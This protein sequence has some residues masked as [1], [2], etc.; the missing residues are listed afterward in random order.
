MIPLSYAQRRLW[1]IDRF[2]GPSATYNL[3]FLI[4]LT[5][6]LD[7]AALTAAVRDVVVRHESLRTLIIDNADGVPAQ[8]VV[9]AEDLHLD[10]PL[11]EVAPADREAAVARAAQYAFTLAEEIPVRATLFRSGPQDHQLLLLAHHIATDGESMDPLVRD[12]AA[13]YT[14]R[15]G[16]A[17]PD[18]PELP[19]QYVDYTMWQRDLLGDENDPESILATQLDYW[20]GELTGVPQP[21]RLPADRPRPPVAGRHGDVVDFRIDAELYGRAE[22]L[23]QRTGV[24]APM[25]FQAALAALLQQLGAGADVTIGSTVAGRMDSQLDDLVGFFVNTWVL[26]TDLSGTPSFEDLLGRVR[27]KAMAAYDHQDAPFERLVEMLNPERSTAYHPLFQTMFTWETHRSVTLGLRGGLTAR[28]TALPTPTAKFDLEFSCFADP[29][30]PGLSVSLEY[31]TE[32]FDRSTAEAVAARYVRLVR[33]LVDAPERPV[34]LADV[35]EAGERALVLGTFNETAAETPELGIAGLVERRAA[36]TPDALAVVHDDTELTYA[37]LD[38]RAGLLARELVA[39][40]AG[41]ERVVGL[42]LPRSADLVVAML[43]ILKSGAAYLPID[44][45]Y[46]STRLDHILRDAR[47][48]LVLTSADTVGVLPTT[49]VPTLFVDDVDFD[50]DGSGAA[51]VELPRVRPANAAY[52]MYTSGST[53]VPKGVTITHR[54]VVNGVLRLADAIG[55]DAGT[56]TLA[57]TSVNFDVSVFETIT[58]LAVGGT[59]EVVRD[60]LVVGE[61]GGWSGG[62]I[63]TVPS[64]FAELLDQVGG[65]LQADAVVFAGEALPASLVERVREAIPGVRVVNAYG[66]TESFYATTFTA[67]DTW[68]GTGSA[69]IGAPLGNMRAY[70]L[71]AGLEPVAPGV[72][73]ELYVA[74]NV[75]RGYHSRAALTAERFL[76]DPFGEP[77]A[78]MYRTGDLARWTPDGQ[79]EYAGRDDAQVKVRGFRIEPG[80]IEAALTAHPGVAQAVVTT[81]AGRGST[82][83]VGY[84]VPVD[85]GEGG[86]DSVSSLGDLDLDLTAIVSARDL[87]RFVSGRLPEFMVPSVFVMLDRLPLAPNGKLDHKALPEPEFTGGEYRAPRTAEEVT[88]AAVYAEVLGLERVGVDDDFFAIGGDSIRSIQV[89]SRARAQGVDVT[90]R[91]IFECRTVAELAQAA[92]EGPGRPVLDELDGGGVGFVPLLPIG[93]YLTQ[94]GGGTDRFTMSMTVDLPAGIDERGLLATLG[95]VLDRHD[96][97]RSRLVSDPAPGL[98]VTGPGTVDAGTL[99]HRVTWSGDWDGAWR[100]QAAAELDAAADRLDAQRGVMA[101]FVWFDAGAGGAGRLLILLHHFVVDGVSWRILLPDLAEAWSQVRDGRTP[102]LPEV[103]TSVRRW[104][105]ALAEE[106]GSERRTGELALWRSIVTGPDPD[107]G[108]R[109]FDPAVDVCATVRTVHMDLPTAATET[110]LTTLPGAFR[111][112]VNDGLLAALALAVAKWRSGRGVAEDASA[113]TLIRLEG[114]GR[115]ETAAPGADLSRT[116]GWFTSVYPV[117]LDVAGVDV[118]DALAGGRAAGA[119][120]KAVKEQLLA[121]PDKGVGY[122]MLRHLNPET[123]EILERYPTGQI[124]FN[125]LGHY[126]GSGNMP[127]HLRGLGFTQADGTTELIADLDADMPALATLAVSAY[128][129]DTPQGPRLDARLDFPSGLLSQ[130]E[131]EELAALWRTALEGVAHHAGRPDA[132]GL[133]PSDVPLVTTDQAQ[134]E[135]WEERYPHLADVWPL[136]AMQDGLL[137]HAELAG[138]SFDAYQMQLVFHLNGEVDGARMRAAG[139]ALLER[140]P[141]LRAAFVM[142]D[143]GRRVQLVHEHVELPWAEYDLSD[144]A[145]GERAQRLKRHL[146]EEHARHFD[147]ATAPLVRMSLVK[148]AADRW[149][150]VFTA[151]HVLFDGWSL[152]LVMEDLLR[153]YGSAGDASGLGRIRDY[154]DF[155]TWLADRDEGAAARAWATELSGVESPTLLAPGAADSD[156]EPAGIAMADVPLAPETGRD[157]ARRAADLGITLNTLIQG[158][159]AV[160]LAGL[161]GRQDVVFGTTVSG[162]P[163]QVTGADEMVGLFINSLPVRVNCAPGTTLRELLT[164]LQERQSALLDHHHHGLLDIHQAVGLPT[165]FDTMV[166]YESFPIDAVALS[167]AGAAAGI[168]LTGISPLSGAHYPLVVMALAEPHLKVGI[169]YRPHVFDAAQVGAIAGR[170]ARILELLARDADTPVAALGILEDDERKRILTDWNDTPAATA[171]RTVPQV[172]EAHA[173]RTP[174]A[175]AVVDGDRTLTY[176]DLDERANRLA[177]VLAARGVGQESVVGLALPRSVE[178]IV[179]LLAVEKAGGAYLP[180]DPEYPADRLAFMLSDADPTLVVTD[181]RIAAGLPESPCPFLVLDEPDTAAEITA[182]SSEPLASAQAGHL[183]Q[184]AYLMYTSGS[185][186]RPKGVGVTHRGVVSLAAD[187]CYAGGNHERVLMHNAQ[188]FDASTYDQWIPLLGGGTIVI[189]PPGRLDAAT[190]AAAAREHDVTGVVMTAGLFMVIADEMPEAFTGVREVWS[191]GDAVAPALVRRVL[192]TCPGLRVVNGYGPT[193]ATMATS[194]HNMER[195][196]DIGEVVPIGRPLDS[197]QVYV[198]DAALRPVLPGVPGELYIGGERLARGYRNRSALTAERFVACPFGAPGE[199]MYRTGDVVAW[200]DEGLLVFHGRVDTQVKIRGFR[201]EPAEVEA[202]LSTHPGVAQAVVTVQED[203]AGERRLMGYVVPH[204][205]GTGQAAA[206]ERQVEEWETVYDQVYSAANTVWGEDFTGWDSTYTDRPLALH[207]MREWRDAAVRQI[208]ARAPRRVLEIGVGSGL[209]MAHVLPHVEQYWATD[210]SSAVI[211]RLAHEAEQAGYADRA[212]LRHRAADDVTGLPQGH[213]DT[214]VLNSVVQYFPDADYLDRVLAQAFELLAPGGRIIVGDVRNAATLRLFRAGVQHAHQPEAA[215]SQ[216]RAAITRAMLMEQE[217]VVDPEWFTQWAARHGAA[218]V[219]IRLK[220]GR[221]HNELTRHRYEAVLHKQPA[222]PVELTE[223]PPLY[224]GRQVGDLR[225]LAQLCA[226]REDTE[227][228]RVVGIPNARLTEEVDLAVAA[229]L[230]TAPAVTGPAV[231]PQD[232]WD[233]AAEQGWTVL[234][235]WSGAVAESF[236]VLVFPQGPELPDQLTGLFVPAGRPGR[237][238][239][240]EPA[241]AGRIGTLVGSLRDY[242]TERLP[243]HQVP[244]SVVAIAEV[245]LMASGKLDRKALPVADFVAQATGRDPR[246]PQEELL[247][248]LFA[249]VLGLDRVGIDDDFFALGGHSLLATRL[250]SRIRA[251]LGVEL[252]IRAVFAAPTVVG[253]SGHL[254]EGDRARPPMVRVEPRPERVPLSFAQRRLWFLDK[255]EGPSATYNAP[256]PLRLTGELDPDALAAAVR[257]VVTRH[258]SLRTLFAEDPDGTPYQRVLSA[259]EVRLDVPVVDV[260]ATE[261]TASIM[262]FASYRFDLATEIPVRTVLLRLAERDHVL[263]LMVH[264][265][266]SDGSSMAPMFRDLA[267]AYAARLAGQAPR[268]PELPAQYV[269]YTLWQRDLLGD[270]NDPDSL[271]TAQF[272]YWRGELTG[273]PQPLQLPTDRT[274]PP[275]AS[276]RGAH[277]DFA[278]DP[279]TVAGIGELARE[280]GATVAI[281]LEAALAV[282]L[283][284]LGGGD[285]VTIGSPIANRTDEN[286]TDMVGFFVNTWVLRA[287]LDGNPTFNDVLDQVRTKSLA[288]YDHQDVPFERLVEVLN[289]ERSTAY[290]P[291]FQVMFAWQNFN[292]QDFELSGLQVEFERVPNDTVKF[293]LFFNMADLPGRGVLGVLEYA[294]DLFDEDTARTIADRFV[295]LL[296]R[297]AAEPARPVATVDLVEPHERDLV[298]RG[299]NDTAAET[300]DLTV[301][302]LIAEQAART[303]EATAVVFGEEQL[304]YAELEARTDR[305][306]HALAARG[307]GP[308][309]IVGL[310]LPRSADLVVAMLG[311]L[312]AGGAYLPI[313]PKYPSTRLDH[314]LDDARPALILKSLSDLGE[315]GDLTDGGTDAPVPA[316]RPANAAYVMYTSGSTGVPKGVTITHRDVVN[317]VLRLAESIGIDADT[318]TLAGTSINFDV[319]VFETVTTLAKGGTVEVVRDVLVVGERGGWSGGVISTVPSVLAG[320]LDQA[321]VDITADAVVFA[322]EALPASLVERVREAIPGVRVVNAYGQT[323]SFY[324]TTSTIAEDGTAAAGAPIGAPLGNMRAYV[325]GPGLAPVPVGVVGELYVAGNVARGYHGR[326]A[327]TAE[328]FVPDPFG[329][330]GARMYRTGD[331]ARWRAD[332]QLDYVGRGD[333]QVKVRG[334]RIEPG[335]IEAALT[336]HRAVAQAAVV[337]R[338]V[339]GSTQLVGYVVPVEVDETDGNYDITAGVEARD[340]RKFVSARLPEFMVPAA[341]VMLDR[342][343]LALNGKLDHKALPEPEFT[344]GTYRAPRT[345]DEH[346]L[347]AVY[348]EVLGLENVGVDD[349]FFAVGGDSIRSIQVV[350]RARAQGLEVTPRQIFELRTVA[351]LA[352][353]AA[354][355]RTGTV[356]EELEGGGVGFMPLLPIGHY[357]LELGGGSDRFTMSTVVD[358]PAGIDHDGLAATLGAVVDRHDILRS[359]LVRTGAKGLEVAEPGTVDAAELI[360]RVAWRDGW[361][362][363]D[364][365]ERAAAELDA[366]AGRLDPAAGVMAQFVWFDT[367]SGA[368]TGTGADKGGDTAGRLII[369]L[370][371]FAVDG[372]SWRILLPDLAEAWQQLRQGRTP[373][374]APVATSVRRWSHALAEH[375]TDADRVAELPLWQSILDGPDPAIGSRPFDPAL[376]VRATVET[377]HLEL[378]VAATDTLLTTLPAAFHG[379]VN[380][381][382]LT[383]L[384]VALAQWRRARGV[385]ERDASSALIRLEGHGRE[386]S[387]APGADLS[388]TVGWFTS[389]F[390]VRLDVGGFDLDDAAGGGRAAGGAIK[391]VK[392]QLNAVPDHGIGF[393]V[394]RYLNAETSAALQGH[395]TGQISFNYL[396]RFASA[397]MPESLRGL[398]WTAAADVDDLFAQPDAD[399]PAMATLEVTAYVTDTEDGPRLSAG[400]GFPGG[401]LTRDE[402]QQLADLW[403]TALE[404]LARHAERPDAGGLTPSDVPLVKVSQRDLEVWTESHPGLVDVWPVTPMQSGLLFHSMMADSSFDAYHVQLTFHLSGDVD[405]E[406][407]RRA[408]QV[409]L[410]RYPNLGAAFVTSAAGEPVQLIR[411]RVELPYKVVDLRDL[412]DAARDAEL[413]RLLA[414]DHADHFDP[415]KPPLMRLTLVLMEPGRSELVFTASHALYDGWSIPHLLQ[416]LIRAYGT[417]GDTSELPRV[418]PYRDFLTWLAGQDRDTSVRAWAAELDG[419]DTPTMLAGAGADA[420]GGD[421]GGF[422]SAEVPLSTETSRLLSQ[423]AAELGVTLNV[424]VQGTWGVLLGALT[425]RQDVVFGTTVSG[426]P[427]QVPGVDDMVGLFI[428]ALP[429]RVRYSPEDTLAQVLT[430]LQ[431]SQAVLMDHQNH[432]LSD[433]QDAAGLGTLFDTMV[434]FESY[435]IDRAGLVE[436]HDEAGIAITG[437]RPVTGAHYP[438]GVAAEASPH[439]RT[440]LHYQES[441]FDPATAARI[442]AGLGRLLEQLAAD[443]ETPLG[444][445]DLMPKA[446]LERVVAAWND[447]VTPAAVRTVQEAFAEQAVQGPD[448]I[449]VASGEERVTYRELDERAGRLARVLAARG[450]GQESVVGL[451]LPRSVEQVVAVLA[452][453]KAGGTYLPVD[454]DYPAERLAFLLGDAAPVLLVTDAETSERLF[455]SPCPHLVLDEPGTADEIARAEAGP[456]AAATAGHPDQLA[457]VMYTSG[458]TGLPKGVGTTHRDVVLL[459]ADSCFGKGGHERVLMHNPQSFDASTYEMWIPLLGGGTVVVAPPGRLDA[460][461]L[462]RL[463]TEQGVT[464]LGIAAGLFMTIADESPEAFRGAREVWTVGDVV[465]PASL[466]RALRTC[467]GL[468][469]V[470]GYGPTE[471]TAATAQHLLTDPENIPGTVP[472]G[473]PMEN[474]RLYVLDTALRPVPPGVPGELYVAGQRLARG[475]L[476]RHALTAERFVACPFGGPGERMYRTGDVV[477]WTED[478][479]LVFQ[480]RADTQVKIRGFRIE[481]G[482]VETV[483]AGHPGITQAVVIARDDRGTGKRLVAYVTPAEGEGPDTEE[484]RAFAAERLPEHMVPAAFVTLESIPLAGAGKVDRKALPAPE[485]VS[486]AAYRAPRTPQEEV[487]AGLFAQVLGVEKVGIDDNFFDLGGHSL[488]ATKLISRIRT[489]LMVEVPIRLVFQSP[490]VADVAAHLTGGSEATG[491]SD[492][493]GVVLP[494]KTGGT[495]APVWFIHP[496]FGLCWSYLGMATQL[497]DRPA[498]GIQARGF[499]GAPLPETFEEMVADYADQILDLQPEGPFHLVGHSIGGP[500]GQAVAVELQRRGHDVPLVVLLDAVPGDWFAAQEDARLDLREAR[501]FLENYLPGEEDSEERRALIGNGAALMVQHGR[502]VREFSQPTYRGT[503]LFF[504]ATQSPEAQAAFWEPH[505]EGALHTYDIDATHL[506]L[507]APGPAAEMCSIITRH[508]TD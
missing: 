481:P 76:P 322:G 303:P 361:D 173:A 214:V 212:T 254:S 169:E 305:V 178:Q 158:S 96:I 156:A 183:D 320:L 300:P 193:E 103:T 229:G 50:A 465:S 327:L 143:D 356:L 88:L 282:L 260:A 377:V 52:V 180:V 15:A 42:A 48:C 225:E 250:V 493:F 440:G 460:A 497:G 480:G 222:A 165:L 201:I 301:P 104:A 489:V 435:P 55:I 339:R 240:G 450:V 190:L 74:G 503:A 256:F 159:W 241:A 213:F 148:L 417:D 443:P 94:L 207:E 4:E 308:E 353:A 228:L 127:E 199:R 326:A 147:P 453:L 194:I 379:G 19:V 467:P 395:G 373:E 279:D 230:M 90:P 405:P 268:W 253:L 403:R 433:I 343:P 60:I 409:L 34:A 378:P 368:D 392:E 389:M 243:A 102:E 107:L 280:R 2:E 312:K 482:E 346:T 344:G 187:S 210:L 26:R 490:T 380:D 28:C 215:T 276:H 234:L 14:A 136:T 338:E 472:I 120:V 25:V 317:G 376:D 204:L 72:V 291:L 371:H 499:D 20:R 251:V 266:A 270:E 233:Q 285:D 393:G 372:V 144:L 81:H 387:A 114:H 431:Q 200:T 311:I 162:R 466:E 119:A 342:L 70:V 95:A 98:D 149:E 293:D 486:G 421:E 18:R 232:V 10:V 434:V 47:P 375:A 445:L 363:P 449:A 432:G 364:W 35:L 418:R 442:A 123:A 139:Q 176:R 347:A 61:R 29:D 485:L 100:E 447:T 140:Y 33:H 248:G 117:R 5:G 318:R 411:E 297:L 86:L 420:A 359:R 85:S 78:R 152:P 422:G 141:T 175:P 295:R 238:L 390:P 457:Y 272:D 416:D 332:G 24:T 263:V 13:A 172:F 9:P 351:E 275:K 62:I 288:A 384:T 271:L 470:N 218:G 1:F 468:R 160:L 355:G 112:G 63:S 471:T 461:A 226:A 455:D 227:V 49:D 89:V 17:A 171:E 278:L 124:S 277:V 504:K 269:D 44:P 170:L 3:P 302:Q 118:D 495:K 167:E 195:H 69:P 330:P 456:L 396:G 325:L 146:A 68:R 209:L 382:L 345:A 32:L 174:D 145:D 425:G 30:E 101:Q 216:A 458:S 419:V 358:L 478:G 498:Y 179:S 12:L 71:G 463:I 323:E 437:A 224:W 38:A 310:N 404:G 352:E 348:A 54:D 133:T 65:K 438:M 491:H 185:T 43:G 281:V 475:Y 197:T 459:A 168:E 333:A 313:D 324:A 319:S 235:T 406:R 125:Y 186:G 488:L 454:A 479:V 337:A 39:R 307:V 306:A 400:I 151:H 314:I 205:D 164:D 274:R 196:E 252:P 500:I 412:S 399:M 267:D 208:L 142:A 257:D 121:V 249:E 203:E 202:A 502:M 130:D 83:L 66:Q 8:E 129:T 444:R 341:F 391:A 155:L 181:A 157:L 16:G 189:T 321:D 360:H 217:L 477:A 265:I 383:A 110:L 304:T 484:L 273:V 51:D 298:L 385:D 294:T 182:A 402:A 367:G 408:G 191:A 53:G 374:L 476:G 287:R 109:P 245:P 506:G 462:A 177:R 350:S 166:G 137:F 23:A 45:R 394:L 21:L 407:M 501:D 335:E 369:V 357:L 299:F 40:G 286:L 115:E 246:T 334:F 469:V 122:G 79:L 237:E 138:A 37:E 446:E 31:A 430:R 57:G 56:R 150:L 77:G 97:L 366:A 258:E 219:D 113:S 426:R 448:R 289:P 128:V 474:T 239:A 206:A 262:D 131:A 494:L 67:G 414:A 255:F 231:D 283:N 329:E 92:G 309:T 284:R 135:A 451:A 161:T 188:A 464:G 11:L 242:L 58:T 105:H 111:G 6:E 236:D 261:L 496:G 247:C 22:E 397:D 413:E 429:V 439:L 292:R 290:S 452:V 328:R 154:R 126:T 427:P 331:L 508:L 73:G 424:L 184:L 388:R 436:A 370:H 483:L 64:V 41:P 91:Q 473:G 198:L 428:N 386:E 354:A 340:L 153:L 362:R 82:Q 349:D 505:I 507:N 116:V 99:L 264:H 415:A 93:H 223:A 36:A 87:R 441:L 365:H 315:L 108:G 46:P 211:E 381:G 336:A 84:V 75:A 80:E 192:D 296:D 259:A 220:P 398:G 244:A 316:A 106:A 134:L 163:P 401:L 132:G 492:P 59:L 487:L 221:A 423:R 27:E 410:D 7:V